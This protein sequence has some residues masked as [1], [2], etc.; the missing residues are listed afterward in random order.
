MNSSNLTLQ[1]NFSIN[2]RGI[3]NKILSKMMITSNIPSTISHEFLINCFILGGFL[4]RNKNSLILICYS[5]SIYLPISSYTELLALKS[6]LAV[7]L[8]NSL[9]FGDLLIPPMILS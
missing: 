9:S 6:C 1:T 5:P 4:R 2:N 8:P 7:I 3:D